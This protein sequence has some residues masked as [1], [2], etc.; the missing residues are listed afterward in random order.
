MEASSALNSPHPD[1]TT[2]EDFFGGE[3]AGADPDPGTFDPETGDFA[4][5][6]EA[7][8]QA[9]NASDNR[10]PEQ[11]REDAYQYAT[12]HGEPVTDDMTAA[13]EAFV[14]A[15]PAVDSTPIAA[16]EVPEPLAQQAKLREIAQREAAEKEAAAQATAAAA[17]ASEPEVPA[18]PAAAAAEETPPTAATTAAG[19][20]GTD[21]AASGQAGAS[22]AKSGDLEREYI[23]FQRVPMTKAALEFLLR[24]IESGEAPEPRVAWFELDRATARN[25]NSAVGAAYMKNAE[26]LGAEADLAAV[27]SRSFQVKH[28]APKQVVETNLSIT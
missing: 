20:P 15:N 12:S 16:E 21:A 28:V 7:T 27:S 22:T 23:V 17:L 25:V 26:S 14:A 19:T 13:H 6:A 4:K 3:D 1:D 2:A 11:R 18:E 24:Q 8:V 9:Q 5:P 10:T